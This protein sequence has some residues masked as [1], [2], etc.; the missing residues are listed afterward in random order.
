MCRMRFNSTCSAISS[1]RNN[2]YLEKTPMNHWSKMAKVHWKK[3]LPRKYKLLEEQGTLEQELTK[4]GEQAEEMLANLVSD[5]G[6]RP[7]EAQ[8]IV[9]PQFILLP[10]ESDHPEP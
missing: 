5:G 1:N 7:N 4:A 9:L 8:E 6:M 3:Y 10:P 2:R